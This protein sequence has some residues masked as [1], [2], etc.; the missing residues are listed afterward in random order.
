VSSNVPFT[1]FLEQYHQFN[2]AIRSHVAII[3]ARPEVR[4]ALTATTRIAFLE[5][6][7]R[8]NIEDSNQPIWVRVDRTAER[9]GVSTK[10]VSRT[11]KMMKKKGWIVPSK[12]HDGRNNH[13]EFDGREYLLTPALRRLMSLP[14]TTPMQEG[15]GGNGKNGGIA[16]SPTVPQTLP[17]VSTKPAHQLPIQQVASPAP[18]AAAAL[19]AG[20]NLSKALAI[21]QRRA[22]EERAKKAPCED[23]APQEPVEE[24]DKALVDNPVL[25]YAPEAEECKK[26][27]GLSHGVIYE[28]NKVF[29]L[30]EASLQKGAFDENVKG[31]KPFN[32]PVDLQAMQAELGITGRG[33]GTL[34]NAA[35]RTGHRLQDVWTVK[36][37][38]IRNAGA[39]GG[40]AVKYLLFLMNCGDDFAY[41]ARVKATD[42]SASK[43]GNRPSAVTNNK[44][45]PAPAATAPGATE[46]APYS[47]PGTALAKLLEIAKAT[48]FKRFRHVSNGM[49]V[50][51]F[52][53]AAEVTRGLER[54]LIGGWRD[55]ENFYVGIS[56]GNLVPVSE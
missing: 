24:S 1:E 13:G 20:S 39:T 56:R 16:P 29:S 18:L 46:L 53:G 44:A 36:S 33:I 5:I 51:F 10:S 32:V 19:P 28:V 45:R 22:I 21:V 3:D 17:K 48:R 31:E 35:K 11:I 27:T 43:A 52:D 12:T 41:L 37:D 6:I 25:P 47:T 38:T 26:E 4:A 34:M 54:V 7:R 40:R 55:L 50:R 14:E 49:V 42:L 23:A 8:A 2:C 30:K 15:S 9:I